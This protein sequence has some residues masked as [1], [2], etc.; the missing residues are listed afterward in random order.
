MVIF[1]AD[2]L[3]L[4]QTALSPPMPALHLSGVRLSVLRRRSLLCLRRRRAV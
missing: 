2:Q 1:T 3:A 4:L